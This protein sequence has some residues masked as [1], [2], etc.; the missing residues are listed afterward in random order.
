MVIIIISFVNSLMAI[1]KLQV[2]L[3]IREDKKDIENNK[4]SSIHWQNFTDVSNFTILASFIDLFIF[5]AE[6]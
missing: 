5:E 4:P 2:I 6:V 3:N 1:V